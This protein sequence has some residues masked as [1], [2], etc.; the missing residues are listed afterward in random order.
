MGDEARI[1]AVFSMSALLPHIPA[2]IFC[3]CIFIKIRGCARP[4]SSNRPSAESQQ[5]GSASLTLAHG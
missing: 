1:G 2:R 5:Y 3:A 4:K